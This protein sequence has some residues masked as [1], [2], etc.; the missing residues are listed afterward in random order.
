MAKVSGIY[1]ILNTKNG[2]VYIGQT[3]N[4]NVRKAMHFSQLRNQ[5]HCNFKLQSAF[6]K[7]G[8]SNFNFEILQ[9]GIPPHE[10]DDAEINYIREF[11]SFERGYNCSV[12]GKRPNGLTDIYQSIGSQKDYRLMFWLL[13]MHS[14]VF[15]MNDAL[16]AFY[17]PPDLE[18]YFAMKSRTIKRVIAAVFGQRY[19]MSITN[20][21]YTLPADEITERFQTYSTLHPDLLED[22][23]LYCG[24]S[25]S[26]A[27]R[28][29]L[30]IVKRIVRLMGLSLRK[31]EHPSKDRPVNYS[32]EHESL[33]L[34]RR[35]AQVRLEAIATENEETENT[36]KL[37]TAR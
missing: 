34:M 2:K 24:L 36:R 17:I 35:L 33:E 28:E 37:N 29:P 30:A 9:E 32:F 11:N 31:E 4:F 27:Q 7:Y 12:G 15:G 6:N 22:L 25:R 8:E 20:T 1:I 26:D 14:K 10:I 16:L 19:K 3:G 5:R 23:S 13:L 21:D 18:D